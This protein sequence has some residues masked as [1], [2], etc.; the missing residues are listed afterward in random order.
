MVFS[1]VSRISCLLI[2]S[3]AVNLSFAQ[4]E[5]ANISFVIKN[6]GI[7]VDGSFDENSLTYQFNPDD[8]DA[9]YFKL[10]IPTTTINTGIKG[11]DKHLRKAKYFDVENYPN[12]TFESTK[13]T[14]TDLGYTL[15]GELT[16]KK[17]T[18]TIEIPFTMEEIEGQKSLSGYVELDRRDYGVGKNHLILG[19][20]VRISIKVAYKE[21]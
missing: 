3:L 9:S 15:T 19:D 10:N 8:L 2:A 18:N 16:I 12:L 17:T 5:S 21:N 1:I 14:K 13:I 4:T 11:R 7:G 6:A 20:L